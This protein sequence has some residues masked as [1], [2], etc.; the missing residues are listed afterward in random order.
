MIDVI[1]SILALLAADAPF[2]ASIGGRLYYAKATQLQA[3]IYP[4]V[5][6][7][8]VTGASTQ[9]LAGTSPP[10]TQRVSVDVRGE[11][12]QEVGTITEHVYRVLDNYQGTV[13][14]LTVQ[15]CHQVSDV[16]SSD[17]TSGINGRVVDFR[18][19]HHP[20]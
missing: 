19:T 16:S 10:W 4:D 14:R 17:D 7:Y 18:V 2:M 8:A 12:A 1:P 20:A 15:W 13:G 5:I 3:P 9:G 11:N 6:V